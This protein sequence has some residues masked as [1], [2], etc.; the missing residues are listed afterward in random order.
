[1]PGRQQHSPQHHITSS[2]SHN[3]DS[4]R[5]DGSSSHLRRWCL[6]SVRGPA[7]KLQVVRR[8]K[9][10]HLVVLKEFEGTLCED[11]VQGGQ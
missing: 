6:G 10:R 2:L 1:M 8:S 5:D 3:A 4:S 11:E 9:R 7:D